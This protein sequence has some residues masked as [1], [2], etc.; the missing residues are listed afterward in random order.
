MRIKI[1]PVVIATIVLSLVAVTVVSAQEVGKGTVQGA[2]AA[3][4][5]QTLELHWMEAYVKRDTAF[6]ERS[7]SDDYA[8]SYP[9]GTVLDKKGEIEAVKVERGHAHGNETR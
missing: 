2:K 1:L 9:D 3:E 8:G 4:V 5:V 6:L 7:L